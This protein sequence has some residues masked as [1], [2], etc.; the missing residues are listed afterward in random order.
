MMKPHKLVIRMNKNVKSVLNIVIRK[1]GTTKN[2]TWIDRSCKSKIWF[3]KAPICIHSLHQ[4]SCKF[5]ME[6]VTQV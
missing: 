4:S 3:S 5:A 6:S 1:S 2:L